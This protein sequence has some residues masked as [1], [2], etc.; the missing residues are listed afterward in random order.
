MMAATPFFYAIG[1]GSN[2]GHGRLHQPRR[3]IAATIMR[4]GQEFELVAASPILDTAPL[5]P[6]TRRF[7]NAAV[8]IAT[9]L[10]PPALLGRLQR[11]ER[12]FGR[13]RGRRGGARPLD[14]DL[15]LWSGGGWRSR[16]LALPHPALA[17]RRFVLDPLGAIARDWRLPGGAL[18]IRHLKARLTRR[19][20]HA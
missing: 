10:D 15:L 12:D 14:L 8:L 9:P 1:L 11:I 18:R 7:A 5:G 4:L 2:R 13:R 17:E 20:P 6:S 19:Q 3:L 16:R